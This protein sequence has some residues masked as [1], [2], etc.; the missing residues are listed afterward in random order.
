MSR[1]WI[2]WLA[3]FLMVSF[4]CSFLGGSSGDDD[5][6]TGSGDAFNPESDTSLASGEHEF[7]EFMVSEDTTVTL[8]GDVVIHV[9]GPI[10]INGELKGDCTAVEIRGTEDLTV[11]G[12][13]TN[14][15]SDDDAEGKEIRLIA[16]GDITLGTT[17]SD[18]EVIVASGSVF[19][20]DP[21]GEDL[22]LSPI[23]PDDEQTSFRRPAGSVLA[24][25]IPAARGATRA[26]RPI[27]AGRGGTVS[28]VSTRGDVTIG[29][30]T[31]G[32]GSDAPKL[33]QN[34]TCDN[35]N[36]FGGTGGSV[37]AAARDGKLI[38][39]AGST[40]R[41][42]DGG[43]GG[44]CTA[45]QGCPAIAIGGQGGNGGSVLIGGEGIEFKGA[46]TLF[47]GNGG[48]GGMA[49]TFADSADA[50]CEDGCDATSTGG[51]GGDAGG[52]G[53]L[54]LLPSTIDGPDPTQDG[55]NGGE[56]GFADAVS[57]D[58]ADCDRCPGGAGGNGGTATGTGGQG[59][60]GAR[61]KINEW[62]T[63][64]NSHQKGKGGEAELLGGMGGVGATCCTPP[65]QGGQGGEGGPVNATGGPEGARG[66][67]GGGGQGRSGN[68]ESGDGGDGGDGIPIG[69]GG[70]GGVATGVPDGAIEGA[71]GDDGELC[72]I[73]VWKVYL[74]AFGGG[75]R[76]FQGWSQVLV[77]I[78]VVGNDP[79]PMADATVT[80]QMT[81]AGENQ[82]ITLV[83]D[84]DGAAAGEFRI[85]MYG[86]YTVSVLDVEGENMEYDPSLNTAN[87]VVVEVG[88]GAGGPPV[89]TEEAVE[90]FLK[91]FAFAIRSQDATFLYNR[92]HPSVLDRYGEATCQAYINQ[93]NIPD[94]DI[95]VLS[96]SGPA[97]WE[98]ERDDLSSTVYNAFSI[99]ANVTSD[100]EVS[101]SELHLAPGLGGLLRWFTDCGDPVQ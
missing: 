35:S 23:W 72:K 7:S 84:K 48:E 94:F 57:G 8:D 52:I 1:K 50:T 43:K 100:G 49:S 56:G 21:E 3:L 76:H 31:A 101:E 40:L 62:P 42:G 92:L 51:K 64:P 74:I 65:D 69:T 59:G 11:D 9:D 15:C 16:E 26:R 63:A 46:V 27:R 99:Q 39:Q 77:A 58:G 32:N 88:A 67:G 68:S 82:F 93:F 2:F 30:I 98:Y 71:D 47:R 37:R 73:K 61:G 44:D 34:G 54:I 18:E 28:V 53:Y 87:S 80:L 4:A 85:S 24:A 45:P 36:N 70:A 19:I 10:E 22:D 13:I 25:P 95:E 89:P 83:T 38:I 6:G 79:E 55:A 29:S 90:A 86:T 17:E 14:E 20:S 66:L 12:F 5:T 81:G 60:D 91:A 41:A 75:H 78:V 33:S 97:M 96:I